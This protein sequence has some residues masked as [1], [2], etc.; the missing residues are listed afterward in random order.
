MN[1]EIKTEN[2]FEP[3]DGVLKTVHKNIIKFT[4]S[5]G[6]TLISSL[7][8]LMVCLVNDLEYYIEASEVSVGDICKDDNGLCISVSQIDHI[9]R[10]TEMYDVINVSGGNKFIGNGTVTHNCQFMGGSGTLIN[11]FRLSKM[12]GI[13]VLPNERFYQY[14]PPE[15]GHKYIMTVDTSEG[16]G[17]DYH[18]VH[19]IDVSEYPFEQVA[20]FHCNVTSHLLL[21]TILLKY[22]MMYND[23][24]VYCEIASTGELVMHELFRDLEYENIIMEERK[25]GHTRGLGVKPNKKTKAIG[26]SALKDLIEKGKLIINHNPT[27]KELHTFSEKGTSWEAEEGFHDD[28]VMSLVLFAYLTTQDRFGDFV[29]KEYNLSFDIFRQEV[30]DMMDGD[31]PFVMVANGIDDFGYY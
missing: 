27:I 26:C 1:I 10:D 3:F 4:F 21:P 7:N 13:D 15:P 18:A 19:I 16:R 29:E 25:T 12:V 23:A 5:N 24:Y 17:Q 30:E 6:K 20:V 9:K 28:L 2:G 11:G 8:H 22:A 31:T 14:K